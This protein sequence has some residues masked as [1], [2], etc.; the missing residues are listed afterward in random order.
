MDKKNDTS[1][2][3]CFVCGSVR[4]SNQYT[5][6]VKPLGSRN[7]PYFPFLETHEPPAK[8]NSS[9]LSNQVS[10]KKNVYFSYLVS[11]NLYFIL[12]KI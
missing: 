8:Y 1:E 4:H 5:L 11:I 2:E 7:E 9:A 3:V 12:N 6:N 10:L